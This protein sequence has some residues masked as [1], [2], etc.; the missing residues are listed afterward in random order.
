[1][2]SHII[3]Q[4]RPEAPD[5]DPTWE[6]TT[7]RAILEERDSHAT[8]TAVGGTRL[9]RLAV[10]AATVAALAGGVIV[11]RNHLPQDD[12]RPAAPASKTPVQT[13]APAPTVN[14]PKA[15]KT[16]VPAPDD[17][18][19]HEF[20]ITILDKGKSYDPSTCVTLTPYEFLAFSGPTRNYENAPI[21]D[22][23]A[24]PAQAKARSDG[25][26]AATLTV[27]LPYKP[28]YRAGTGREGKG[29]SSP[30]T[31]P[32]ETKIVTR[33]DS[34]DVTVVNYRR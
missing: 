30:A 26:C 20:R 5:L 21:G 33:G 2:K 34:Q 11:A 10:V 23:I 28:S 31:D 13:A 7:L 22:T 29:I 1:M 32:A 16:Y 14:A 4:L 6:S 12:V 3:D 9:V 27:T 8:A 18:K 15:E 25:T 19:T 17:P 24:L